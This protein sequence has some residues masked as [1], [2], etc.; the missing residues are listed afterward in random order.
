MKKINIL[1]LTLACGMTAY[2]QKPADLNKAVASIITYDAKGNVLNST[3]GFFIGE[4][5]EVIAPYQAFKSAVRADVINWQ[6]QQ[7]QVLR[8]VGASSSYDLIRV[9]TDVPTKKLNYLT[10]SST[11][12]TQG[13]TLQLPYYTT[14]KKALPESTTITSASPWNNH[15]YYE[16][17]APNEERFV[18][19]P[20]LDA[21]N[22]VMA[23]I[24][25]NV[26]KDATTAC[27][28]DVN[29]ALDLN[30]SALSIF[31][32]DLNDVLIPK[33]VPTTNEDDAF[34][35]VYMMLHSQ[36]APEFVLTASD[37]FIAAF[38]NNAKIYAERAIYQA[39]RGN[40]AE[41]DADLNKGIALGGSALGDLYNTRS[42]LM[43]NKV[44]NAEGGNDAYPAWTLESALES[45]RQAYATSPQPIYL[46]QE[47]HV[48]F[49]MQKYQEA[50]EQFQKVNASELANAQS[51]YYAANALEHANG[52]ESQIIALLD[53][54]VTHLKTP[55]NADA[56]PYIFARAQRLDN[57]G[58]HRRATADYNEYEKII[59]PSNLN[60]YFYFLRMQSELGSRMYQQALDDIATAIIRAASTDE[61]KEYLYQQAVLQLQV[62]LLDECITSCEQ[63]IAIDS[64]DGETYKILGI[65]YGE[66]GNKAKANQ[67][68]LKA[69]ELK[70]ENVEALLEKYKK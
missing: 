50:Y 41:A 47:G 5:G 45:S 21:N 59:G 40:Y 4:S 53:S 8:V 20:V 14:E 52:E 65:A 46:I 68:L 57:A 17:S 2:A 29:F 48:L 26:L 39:A 35:Y 3:N 19:C 16:V 11:P 51:F 67:N 6:G 31:S 43:Y 36:L 63:I 18:G 22:Q 10:A 62:K 15:Y 7:S 32:N 55:Y 9:T 25:K 34:S 60:A 23:M 37:D 28:I 12:A 61:K 49:S 30:T 64:N 54:C 38:P 56:A 24:Q 66:K 70:A 58:Q 13:Q 42:S 44:I 27:A 1:L 69:K 33:L